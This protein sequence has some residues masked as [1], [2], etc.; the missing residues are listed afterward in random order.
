MSLLD[1]GEF[2]MKDFFF[3]DYS[4]GDIRSGALIFVEPFFVTK[5]ETN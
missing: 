1:R 5:K 2:L 3:S 4:G